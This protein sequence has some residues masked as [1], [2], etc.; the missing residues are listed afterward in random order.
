MNIEIGQKALLTLDN[1]FYAPDGNTY[2][3]VFGT[4]HAVRT[5]EATLGI[6]PNGKSTNW[7]IEIG[8]T[9]VAGCQVHFAVRTDKC[10]TDRGRGWT[11]NAEHGLREWEAPCAIYF[12]DEV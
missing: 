10:S 8:D 11:A 9:T 2:K 3:A 4:V 12:A 6:R 5:A 1:W 7:Y